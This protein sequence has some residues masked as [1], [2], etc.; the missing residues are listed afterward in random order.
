MNKIYLLG[1]PGAGKTTTGKWLASKLGWDFVDLD[2]CIEK[3]AGKSVAQIFEEEGEIYFRQIEALALTETFQLK[4][5]VVSCGGGT[6]AYD[7]NMERMSRHGL[8]VFLNTEI[9][10]IENRLMAQTHAR[11]LFQN[12][13]NEGIRHKLEKLAE[14]RRPYYS[15]AK[16]IWNKNKPEDS[17]FNNINKLMSLYPSFS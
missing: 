13:S 4:N 14:K 11:P 2:E 15:R 1:L 12:E 17:F 5:C 7:D 10:E 8:T 16:I 6:P 9:D 3:K